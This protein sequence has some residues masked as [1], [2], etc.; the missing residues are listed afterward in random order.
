MLCLP[1]TNAEYEQIIGRI[2]RPGGAFG[3]VE[4]IVPEVLL[5]NGGDTWSWD[6]RRLAVIHFKKT[7]SDCCGPQIFRSVNFSEFFALIRLSTRVIGAGASFRVRS[8]NS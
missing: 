1:W 7:L 5:D 3:E 4:I 8:A 6:Q 2:R